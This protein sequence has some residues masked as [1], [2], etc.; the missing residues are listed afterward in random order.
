MRNYEL[1]VVLNPELSDD[2]LSTLQGKVADWLAA[3]GGEVARVDY[4]GRRRLAYPIGKKREGAY[5]FWFVRL[6]PEAPAVVER[7]L[8]I[9][10]DVMRFL[11]VRHE[12]MPAA[13]VVPEPADEPAARA[14][15]AP[16]DAPVL[17]AG[18]DEPDAATA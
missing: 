13:P 11:F 12:E 17:E 10:E 9:D 14:G 5:V 6:P 3:A 18:V 15:V 16:P 2:A 8:R 4:W 1:A 7:K